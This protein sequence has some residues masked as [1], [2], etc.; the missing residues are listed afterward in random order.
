MSPFWRQLVPVVLSLSIAVLAAAGCASSR[1][2]IPVDEIRGRADR[3]FGDLE[4]GGTQHKETAFSKKSKQEGTRQSGQS[5]NK[6]TGSVYAAA[7]KKPDWVDGSAVEYPVEQYLTGVGFGDTRRA[8]EDSAYAAISRIFQAQ[9][10]SRTKEL[11]KYVQTEIRGKVQTARD[12]QIDQLTSVATK[13]VLEDIKIAEMWVGSEK[14]TYALAI[15]DRAHAVAVLRE[16][17]AAMDRDVRGL[18]GKSDSTADKVEAVRCLRRAMKILVN[19]D[20]YNTDLRIVN[21]A[22]KGI[23]PPVSLTSIRQKIQ[24]LLAN[25]IHIGVEVGGPHNA[26]IRSAILEGLTKEGFSIEEGGEQSKIDIL[27]KGKVS[28]EQADLPKWKFVRWAIS[29]DLVNQ[30]NG[31]IFGSLTKNGREGHL[32]FPEA[33]ERAAKALQKEIV[34]KLSAMMV[35]FI[36]GQDG[37]G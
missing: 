1:P 21:P 6:Q 10:N 3:A 36:Y 31:K 9:I 32:N 5:E 15:M 37:G 4:G 14:L 19:R 27:V 24:G 25:D 34:G 22:G 11:E 16:R 17:V 7:G 2:S 18:Q 26:R 8:A 33:E 13:K 12:I 20:V 29:V 30:S 35:S 23:D 28:F